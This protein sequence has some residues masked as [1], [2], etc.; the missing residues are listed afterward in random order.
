V[1]CLG[2][3]DHWQP[4]GTA[5]KYQVAYADL[6]RATVP[7]ANCNTSRQAASSASAF[8]IVVW[9]TDWAS[10]YGYPAGGNLAAINQVVIQPV[11]K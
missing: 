2:N 6:V 9:G 5:G 3:V 8:G 11:V 1:E 7:V 10:S 4:V